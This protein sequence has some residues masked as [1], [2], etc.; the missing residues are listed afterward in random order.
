ML[1]SVSPR[2]RQFILQEFIIEILKELE[3][4]RKEKLDEKI[5]ETLNPSL[6]TKELEEEI[7]KPFPKIET[8][9][10]QKTRLIQE[11]KKNIPP[12]R[13]KRFSKTSLGNLRIPETR[14]PSR[15]QYLKPTPT[16]AEIDLGDLNPLL[17][18][19]AVKIIECDGAGKRIIVKGT[20][21]IKPTAI[22]LEKDEINEVIK[23][24]SETTKIPIQEGIYKVVFGNLIFSSIFSE[25]ISSKFIIR[26]MS[27][28]QAHP[29]MMQR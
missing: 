22:T 1:N 19:P 27:Y 16:K 7:E 17:K 5:E 23:K 10:I 3:S 2:T 12:P 8:K 4:Q 11:P 6:K 21:G 9:F 26:K 18:D 28:V 14:L 13:I 29:Q 15:L 25:V 20:M 24:F